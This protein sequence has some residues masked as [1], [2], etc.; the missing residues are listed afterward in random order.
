MNLPLYQSTLGLNTLNEIIEM[1][2]NTIVDTNRGY[3]FF[4]D[5]GK[6]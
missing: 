5:Y 3:K 2:H 4:V 6:K 1:F